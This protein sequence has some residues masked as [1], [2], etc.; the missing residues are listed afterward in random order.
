MKFK[1]MNF[2]HKFCISES[3]VLC[4]LTKYK[5]GL[6][7]KMT[8]LLPSKHHAPFAH[9]KI[10]KTKF[11]HLTWRKSNIYQSHTNVKLL[12]KII[13]AKSSL[14]RLLLGNLKS[15]PYN[16][17]LIIMVASTDV[18]KITKVLNIYVSANLVWIFQH[19]RVV[20]VWCYKMLSVHW[21]H[22][23]ISKQCLQKYTNKKVWLY[24][25]CLY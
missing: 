20:S 8:R 22:I 1:L 13:R 18:W 21:N 6:W 9:T 11:A 25:C 19:F 5:L 12:V 24:L 16:R 23:S 4:S 3:L 14:Y 2:H 15:R 10:M 17:T 7:T